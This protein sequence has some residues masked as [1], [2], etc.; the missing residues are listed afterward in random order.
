MR[1]RATSYPSLSSWVEDN[2][3]NLEL[4][5]MVLNGGWLPVESATDGQE[6]LLK[7]KERSR[8]SS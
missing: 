8:R 2:P 4:T 6:G 1:P 3:S 5:R 7:A